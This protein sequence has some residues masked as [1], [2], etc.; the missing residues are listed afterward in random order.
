MKKYAPSAVFL[1]ILGLFIIPIFIAQF[2]KTE[3]RGLEG[4][5]LED[6]SFREISFRNTRPGIN[7][8]G[9][10][11][12][13]EGEGPFPAAVVI[14]GSGTSQRDSFWYLTLTQYL[15]KNG[16]AVLL[17][18]KRGS[19]QSEGDWRTASFEDLATD[20]WAAIAFLREQEEIGISYVGVVGMSQGGHIAPIVANESSSVAFLVDVV[21]AS[22][23][24]H[25][26]LL[27]EENHNL[28]ELGV[29]PG[30]SNVLAYGTSFLIRTR[31][32]E[33]WDAIGNFDPI[34]Y[35]EKVATSCLVLYGQEDTNVPSAES[36]ERL[37]SLD[38]SNITVK[39]Y[40]GSGH[41]LE[42]PEGEGD[43]VFREDALRDIR[44]FIYS[45]SANQ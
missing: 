5:G 16:I 2:T 32:R 27:Y 45:A 7:L 21:G 22:V 34:P 44:D 20:T 15:Q 17:P 3:G 43:S 8:G 39:V 1:T 25:E 4:V 37:R 12:I 11:F 29:L 33:F 28:R 42:D 41:P 30:I 23:T 14:H 24:M 9:M 26:Q 13:P 18:D 35:W 36:A 31:Q 40:E 38:K 6:T 10:L 19:E